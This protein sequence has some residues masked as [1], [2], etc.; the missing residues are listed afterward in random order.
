LGNRSGQA[1]SDEERQKRHR[2]TDPACR[3]KAQVS[4]GGKLAALRFR[5]AGLVR[6][7]AFWVAPRGLLW[8]FRYS[9]VSR[10]PTYRTDFPRGRFR[11]PVVP[12]AVAPAT[13]L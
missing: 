8:Q 11:W 4:R 7:K 6:G 2:Q 9:V 13:W 3:H 1:P 5:M 10:C 12:T